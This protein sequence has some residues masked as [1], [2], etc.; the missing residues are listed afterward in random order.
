VLIQRERGPVYVVRGPEAAGLD[1][2]L[3]A[4]PGCC[5]PAK[6]SEP[7]GGNIQLAPVRQVAVPAGTVEDRPAHGTRLT[8]GVGKG[9]AAAERVPQDR[10]VGKAELAAEILVIGHQQCHRQGGLGRQRV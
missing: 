4:S 2:Q 6:R 1:R 3:T 10:P 9:D 8:A 5:V 7:A